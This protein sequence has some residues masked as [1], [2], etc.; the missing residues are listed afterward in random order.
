MM[1]WFKLLAQSHALQPARKHCLR[2]RALCMVIQV[3]GQPA[4]LTARPYLSLW[5]CRYIHSDSHGDRLCNQLCDLALRRL[6]RRLPSPLLL[7]AA[8]RL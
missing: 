1:P 4:V 7:S 3:A 2:S 5:V 8:V 6:R